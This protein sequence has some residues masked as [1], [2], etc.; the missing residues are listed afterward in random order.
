[1]KKFFDFILALTPV[2]AVIVAVAVLLIWK[3][4]WL[5]AIAVAIVALLIWLWKRRTVGS[6][7]YFK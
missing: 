6:E 4:I 7:H 3:S 2:D 1:M 5:F